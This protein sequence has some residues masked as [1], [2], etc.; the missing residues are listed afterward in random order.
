MWQFH[1]PAM[2]MIEAMSL[3]ILAWFFGPCLTGH[4]FVLISEE[5]TNQNNRCC[6][7]TII[8]VR[9]MTEGQKG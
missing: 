9:F 1:T 6:D 8:L 4:E 2:T 5:T 7:W 3:Q